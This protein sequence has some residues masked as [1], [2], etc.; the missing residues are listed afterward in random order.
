MQLRIYNGEIYN[1][2]T[3]RYIVVATIVV[4]IILYALFTRQFV[5]AV[6][7]ILIVGGYMFYILWTQKII[8]VAMDET[9]IRL[10]Q[11]YFPWQTIDGYMVEIERVSQ[12]PHNII[13]VRGWVVMIHTLADSQENISA[14]LREIDQYAEYLPE[15]E[16]SSV[17]KIIRRLKL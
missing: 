3:R 17:E 11:S 9:G 2:P 12:L 4:S 6:I 5:G 1:R 10:D 7:M 15:I 16:E 13:F 8:Y 14:F